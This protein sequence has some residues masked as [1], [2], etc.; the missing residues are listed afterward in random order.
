M[1]MYKCDCCGACCNGHLIVEAYEYDI[2]REPLLWERGTH[3][4]NGPANGRAVCLVAVEPCPFLRIDNRC[5]IYPTRPRD[6]VGM[7]A[8]DEQCQE[9]RRGAGLPEL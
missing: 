7:Q 9:S 8:G 2:Q 4:D 6:C 1:T 5:E 3:M